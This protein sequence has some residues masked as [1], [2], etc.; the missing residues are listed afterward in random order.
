MIILGGMFYQTP[1]MAMMNTNT[2][3][4]TVLRQVIMVFL[5]LNLLSVVV[6]FIYGLIILCTTRFSHKLGSFTQYL[7]AVFILAWVAIQFF[8]PY[9]AKFLVGLL[10]FV[11][12]S[13]TYLFL[14]FF[15]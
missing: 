9:L 3:L 15:K 10:A 6:Y 4:V 1:V 5:W 12:Q 11:E 7:I 13:I 14:Y 8:G 2:T